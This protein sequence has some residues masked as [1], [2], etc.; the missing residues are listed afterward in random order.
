MAMAC[1]KCQTILVKDATDKG[2]LSWFK[3]DT[4]HGCPGCKGKIKYNRRPAGKG[5]K[6][7]SYVHTCSNCGDESAYCCSTQPGKKTKGMEDK[8][9]K[10]KQ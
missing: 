1:A 3:S 10:K 7:R 6:K 4:E 9:E 2:F 8:A 5:T